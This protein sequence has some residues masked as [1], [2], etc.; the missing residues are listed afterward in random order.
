MCVYSWGAKER[1]VGLTCNNAGPASVLCMWQE[2]KICTSTIIDHRWVDFMENYDEKAS[3]Y[4]FGLHHVLQDCI[5][6]LNEPIYPS[7]LLHGF[8]STL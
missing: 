3:F 5:L 1:V 2:S 4:F 7:P 8:I 6:V